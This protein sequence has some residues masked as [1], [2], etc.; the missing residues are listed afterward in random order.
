MKSLF[1]AIAF[2]A[3]IYVGLQHPWQS[4]GY[5]MLVAMVCIGLAEVS[6]DK[7]AW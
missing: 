1:S 2:I 4:E 3:V 5:I 7:G 6:S